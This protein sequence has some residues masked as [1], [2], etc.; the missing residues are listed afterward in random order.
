VLSAPPELTIGNIVRRVLH[1]IRE[2]AAT[3]EAASE[4]GAGHEEEG[5]A[6]RAP[7]L[8]T[9]LEVAPSPPARPG[10]GRAGRERDGAAAAKWKV[11][12]SILEAVSELLEELDGITAAIAEQ[13][14]EHVHANEV[15]LT[16]G[17]CGTVLHF[18]RE[19][20]KKRRFQVV[21]A[22]AAP[23]YRGQALA[24]QLA[25]DGIATTC[26]TDSAVFAMMA[27]ANMVL[28][29]AHAVLANGGMLGACGTHVTALAAQRHAVPV[30]VLTG[31][32]KLSPTF[33]HDPDV[34]LNE[35]LSPALLLPFD[36]I[37]DSLSQDGQGVGP[38]LHAP[39]PAY[40]YVPPE[41]IAL[42]LTDSGC[43]CPGYIYRLLSEYYHPDDMQL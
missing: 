38:D 8:A 26:I 31:L 29:G 24:R 2:E 18:L 5:V 33:P 32:H 25:E 16:A 19:A 23:G 14:L 4:G 42:F 13:A 7:S 12:H 40:D 30:V 27:R 17:Y 6:L 39:T 9:L 35:L 1:I 22:E 28:L 10:K 3:A 21:V 15:I 20:A 43:H 36:A 37:A 34:T 11:R 41:L